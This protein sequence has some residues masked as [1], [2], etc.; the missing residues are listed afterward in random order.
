MH[1]RTLLTALAFALALVS[2]APAAPGV[3]KSASAAKVKKTHGHTIRGEV[4]EV[5]HGKEHSTITLKVHHHH[6]PAL[7]T[8][9]KSISARAAASPKKKTAARKEHTVKIE[10]DQ[11]TRFELVTHH[12]GKAHHQRTTLSAVHKGEHVVAHLTGH[13]HHASEV[14]ILVRGQKATTTARP[15]ARPV[16]KPTAKKK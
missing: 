14:D 6:H 10:V 11:H 3:K 2:Q 13:H 15:N 8:S 5:H 1:V 16:V 7:T 9:K 4:L 12:K